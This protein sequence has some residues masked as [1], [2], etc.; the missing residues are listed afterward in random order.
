MTQDMKPASIVALF[1]TSKAERASF[2]TMLVEQ[3]GNG[4]VDP[5]K[6]HLQVKAMEEVIENLKAEPA[7]KESVLTAAQQH[8]KK[9]QYGSAEVA[10]QE[11]GT[12]YDYSGTNDPVIDRLKWQADKAASELKERQKFLQNIP[13]DGMVITDEETGETVKVYPPA[14]SSTTSVVVRLK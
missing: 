13:T 2:V 14:K 3:I 1:E 5:L 6:I 12:K 7:Y 10:I 8:G 9:F 11:V 4:E